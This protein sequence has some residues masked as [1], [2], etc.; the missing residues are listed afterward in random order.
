[1]IS[2]VPAA[3]NY[4]PQERP[5]RGRVRTWTTATSFPPGPN[6]FGREDR[7]PSIDQLG[8]QACVGAERAQ[9]RL[10]HLVTASGREHSESAPLLG[11][12]ACC[13]VIGG[14]R[15]TKLF[16]LRPIISPA[17]PPHNA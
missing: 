12:K 2:K 1:M 15:H 10:R 16:T 3:I 11:T 13:D 4:R 7:Q 5:A 8:Y 17:S 6:L 14:R 9:Q